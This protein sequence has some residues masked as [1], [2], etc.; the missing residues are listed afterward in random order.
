MMNQ[1]LFR[2]SSEA[3]AQVQATSAERSGGLDRVGRLIQV[4]LALYLVPVLVVVLAVGSFG[5]LVLEVSDAI[6]EFHTR[7]KRIAKG[8]HEAGICVET[9]EFTSQDSHIL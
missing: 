1:L 2:E 8:N 4:A 7:L 6:R 3:E 9:G 5:M